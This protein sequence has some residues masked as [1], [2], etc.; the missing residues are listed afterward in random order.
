MT[1]PIIEKRHMRCAR[2]LKILSVAHPAKMVPKTAVSSNAATDQAAPLMF[3]P[4]SSV[5]NLGPQSSTPMRSTYT[6][7]LAIA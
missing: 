7:I 4:R 3:M 6:K 1:E 5:R 2:P